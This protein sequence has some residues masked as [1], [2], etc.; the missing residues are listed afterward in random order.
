MLLSTH[1]C[2]EGAYDEAVKGVD[3]IVHTASP[4]HGGAKDPDGAHMVPS[5]A[6]Q[7]TMSLLMIYFSED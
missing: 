4:A 5:F 1:S 7:K 3:A 2:Q 6:H